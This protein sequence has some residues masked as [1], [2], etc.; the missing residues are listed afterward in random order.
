VNVQKKAAK[1]TYHTSES[2]WE[3]LSQ[4]RK[5]ARIC[6]L[7]KA[8]TGEKAWTFIGE[9]LQRPNYL[10]RIDHD[11]KIRN[12]RQRTDIRKFSFVNRTIRL[13][14]RLPAEILGTLPCKTSAFRKRVR[15]VIN[16]VN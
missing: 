1:F 10:S 3:T 16:V 7:F 14:N 5:I 4:R 11:W 9:R 12:R 6:A 2:N 15:K 8:Y 13:W